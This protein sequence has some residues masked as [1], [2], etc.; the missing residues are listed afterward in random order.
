MQYLPAASVD[1]GESTDVAVDVQTLAVKGQVCLQLL[2]KAVG[3]IVLPS[4]TGLKRSDWAVSVLKVHGLRKAAHGCF[5]VEVDTTPL[6]CVGVD[7]ASTPVILS[8]EALPVDSLLG[9]R[10][11]QLKPQRSYKFRAGSEA[12]KA[13]H[14][15]AV[16]EAVLEDLLAAGSFKLLGNDS[17]FQAEAGLLEKLS[18][19]GMVKRDQDG[20][21]SLTQRGML[22]FRS[23]RCCARTHVWSEFVTWPWK[24]WRSCSCC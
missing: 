7:S 15:S 13:S 6:C 19:A 8:L 10:H 9:L 22:R 14:D 18:S 23:A 21:W 16:C 24:I 11:W 5:E 4:S 2:R 12:S 17:A 3:D 20:D 1:H